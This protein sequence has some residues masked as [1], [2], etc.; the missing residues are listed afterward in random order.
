MENTDRQ[1]EKMA[2]AQRKFDDLKR[3]HQCFGKFCVICSTLFNPGERF[4]I[5][6]KKSSEAAN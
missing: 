2:D 6:K 5:R 4:L 1:L 3:I